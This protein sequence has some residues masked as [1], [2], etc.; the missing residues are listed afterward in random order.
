MIRLYCDNCIRVMT[1]EIDPETV[2]CIVTS[3]PYNIGTTYGD[4]DDHMS[5]KQYMDMTGQW[6]SLAGECM[7][8]EGSLFLN[9]GYTNTN[10][11]LAFDVLQVARDI[12][13][14]QNVIHWIKAI[15][16]D[17]VGNFGH[18]KPVNSSRYVNRCHEY[19]FHLTHK[20]TVAIDRLSIGVPYTDT[21]NISRWKSGNTVR[22]RG[23]TWYIPYP[24][25]QKKREKKPH[26]AAF[27]VALPSMCL[28][29]HGIKE[30]DIVMDPFMG[31]G[32][33]GEAAKA[34]KASFIG[35][36]TDSEYVRYAQ[37]KLI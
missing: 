8:E 12:F 1:E 30:G 9:I 34:K 3:P 32:T 35:I 17:G 33:T 37:E 19:I 24:T 6:L 7:K 36:D 20:G 2:D 13:E 28:S 4:Y 29:L 14:V 10:P 26:P 31:I 5:C 25:T 16:I 27:P 21:S 23:N 18:F 11:Y 15:S 22:C